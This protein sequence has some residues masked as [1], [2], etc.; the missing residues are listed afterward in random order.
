MLEEGTLLINSSI[1]FKLLFVNLFPIENP[2]HPT[3]F[4]DPD[5]F[6]KRASKVDPILEIAEQRVIIVPVHN[7]EV[8]STITAKSHEIREPALPIVGNGRATKLSSATKWSQVCPVGIG[9]I[10]WA[11]I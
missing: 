10:L 4:G 9:S 5:L 7:N 2:T 6:S 1:P 11:E 8:N 3:Y